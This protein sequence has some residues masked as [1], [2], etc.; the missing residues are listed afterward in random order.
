MSNNLIFGIILL[1]LG[2]ICTIYKN[3][4]KEGSLIFISLIFLGL[5]GGISS[6]YFNEVGKI[7]TIIFILILGASLRYTP[8]RKHLLN[9]FKIFFSLFK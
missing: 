4:L 1:I 6:T 9:K 7:I 5:I 8:T 2:L 3:N